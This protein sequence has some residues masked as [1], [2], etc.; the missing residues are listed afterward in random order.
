[1]PSRP[2]RAIAFAAVAASLL[3]GAFTFPQALEPGRSDRE[4]V[5]LL[6]ALGSGDWFPGSSRV[7]VRSRPQGGL[8]IRTVV[9]GRLLVTR[10]LPVD[11]DACYTALVR[12]RALTPHVV[13]ALYDESIRELLANE[14]VPPTARPA[15][16]DLQFDPEGNA[17][18]TFAII[19]ADGPGRASI[20]WL[21][22]VRRPC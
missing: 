18:V 9:G 15:V 21:R 4:G 13:I 6:A 1:M 14:T 22:L 10:G 2:V 11:P 12:A 17:R 16:Q 3:V 5:T 20:D 19:G 8:A 7:E